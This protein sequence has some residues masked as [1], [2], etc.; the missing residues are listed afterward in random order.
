MLKNLTQNLTQNLMNPNSTRRRCENNVFELV[1][2]AV[3]AMFAEDSQ[4]TLSTETVMNF[5]DQSDTNLICSDKDE[6]LM[7][8]TGKEKKFPKYISS[9]VDQIRKNP[10]FMETISNIDQVIVTGKKIQDSEIILLNADLDVKDAKSDIYFKMKTMYFTPF[11]GMSVKQD[12]HCTKT[13]Y[14]VTK[15]FSSE[16]RKLCKEIKLD[17]LKECTRVTSADDSKTKKEK[18][19]KINSKFYER[20]NPYFNALAS[21]IQENHGNITTILVNALLSSKVAYPVY[22]FDGTKLSQLT[23]QNPSNVYFQEEESFYFGKKGIRRQTAKMFY[24]LTFNTGAIEV[25]YRVEIRWKGAVHTSS[26]QFQCHA[27]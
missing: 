6:Y 8:K 18:R 24:K 11:I 17:Y 16:D 5:I 12:K 9:L 15:L 1:T 21:K 14:S 4:Q 23:S 20:N 13:N 10:L 7:D 2:A 26:P 27:I 3:F 22:E 25:K 19:E